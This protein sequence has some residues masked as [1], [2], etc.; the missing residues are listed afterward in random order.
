MLL[1]E[2]FTIATPPRPR[3]ASRAPG[4]AAAPARRGRRPR[5][6]RRADR[7]QFPSLPESLGLTRVIAE[8]PRGA[9]DRRPAATA[10]A[11]PAQNIEHTLTGRG[12]HPLLMASVRRSAA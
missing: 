3:G 7:F 1:P 2:S 4:R 11:V 5:H 9:G 10:E 12:P 6:D 8:L